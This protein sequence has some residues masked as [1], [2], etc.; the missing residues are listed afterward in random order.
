MKYSLIR[1]GKHC[2]QWRT[3][4][5][6]SIQVFDR[7]KSTL[8]YST[9]AK[10]VKTVRDK[11]KHAQPCSTRERYVSTL[12]ATNTVLYHTQGFVQ[13][14]G[15]RADFARVMVYLKQPSDVLFRLFES[16]F[17]SF[18]FFQSNHERFRLFHVSWHLLIFHVCLY[19]C[20]FICK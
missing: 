3:K 18:W 7:R 16:T 12:H 2:M 15:D 19:V 10:H 17:V 13:S 4:R 1:L 6:N 9:E 5:W 20:V 8:P 14:L 11:K